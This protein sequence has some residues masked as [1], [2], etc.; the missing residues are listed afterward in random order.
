MKKKQKGK[1]GIKVNK[2][3][4]NESKYREGKD[5]QVTEGG[6][7]SAGTEGGRIDEKGRS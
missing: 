3:L 4:G 2:G 7:A 5:L 1:P 6:V